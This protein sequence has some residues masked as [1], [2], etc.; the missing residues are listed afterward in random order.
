MDLYYVN[1]DNSKNPNHNN[2]V[3][4][5]DCYW[6]KLAHATCNKLGYYQ[7]GVQAVAAAKRI[8]YTRADGCRDCC[9]EAHKG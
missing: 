7:N 1:T 2:E 9:P 8:G 6:R 3:H 4:T 5:Q